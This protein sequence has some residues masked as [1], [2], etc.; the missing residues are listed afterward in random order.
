MSDRP[1][2]LPRR[3][4][5]RGLL[6]RTALVSLLP[7]LP[8]SARAQGE[9][10]PAD[11]SAVA[12][13]YTTDHRK[14]DR[15]RWS[16]KSRENAKDPQRCGNCAMRNADGGCQLFGGRRVAENGWCNAWTAR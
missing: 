14:V 12:L 7:L 9:L 1:A 11:P 8:A 10:D 2:N 6:R 5:R 13:G 4:T 16:K 15:Q 3:L